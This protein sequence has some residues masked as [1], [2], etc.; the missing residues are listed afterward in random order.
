MCGYPGAFDERIV[1]EKPID[2]SW[3]SLLLVYC[4]VH[5]FV[6]QCAHYLTRNRTGGSDFLPF[7]LR[8]TGLEHRSPLLS[9]MFQARGKDWF[10]IVACV[11]FLV[12]PLFLL[13][14]IWCDLTFP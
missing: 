7:S 3:E 5:S 9:C 14:V 4:G 1:P 11:R 2:T 13:T 10:F 12:K 6:L 8:M